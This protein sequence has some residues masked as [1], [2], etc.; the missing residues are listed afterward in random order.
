MKKL[1]PLATWATG[2]AVEELPVPDVVQH[3]GYT[4]GPSALLAVCTY[5][6]IPTSEEE[7][8][9]FADTTPAGTGPDELAK[10][11][12]AVGLGAE[13]REDMSTDDLKAALDDGHPVLVALQ[14]W[15]P[16]EGATEHDYGD[17]WGDGHWVVATAVKGNVALFEDPSVR[18]RV[19][20]TLN[21]LDERWHDI[22]SGKERQGIGIV[23]TS[24][25]HEE[26]APEARPLDDIEPMG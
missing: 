3:T 17:E 14:A 15:H 9:E 10:A 22:D 1:S 7:L 2:A 23:F 24:D 18:G 19:L 21:E 20:L 4:C 16:Q 12:R 11:A 13:V 8:A 26:P 25:I 5:F 6:G